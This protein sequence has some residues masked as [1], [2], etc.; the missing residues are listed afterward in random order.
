MCTL[1]VYN[2]IPTFTD[3]GQSQ[4]HTRMMEDSLRKLQP[5]LSGSASSSS[6]PGNKA[7]LQKL[8]EFLNASAEDN[9]QKASEILVD[10][11]K[12]SYNS[13]NQWILGLKRMMD[14]LNR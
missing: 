4:L 14:I 1:Y 13:D 8:S 6:T 5:I 7:A 9:H 12:T 2:F 10:L 3:Q 11:M